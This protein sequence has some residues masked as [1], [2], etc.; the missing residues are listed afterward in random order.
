MDKKRNL[1]LVVGLLLLTISFISASRFPTVGGDNSTWGSVLNDYLITLSGENATFLNKTF[2]N[3]SNIYISSVNSTHIKDGTISDEDISDSTN[4]T[5]GQK[6]VFE[7]GESIGNFIDGWIFITG[8]LNMSNNNITDVDYIEGY[9]PLLPITPEYPLTKYLNGNRQWTSIIVGS[10]ASTNVYFTN[11]TSDVSGY[12]KLS[13]LN[14]NTEVV[15]EGT[16]PAGEYLARTYLYD[17]QIGT[18]VIDSGLWLANYN[19][20]VSSKVQETYMKFEAFMRNSNGTET[21]LFSYY[22]PEIDNTDYATL[23]SEIIEPQFNINSTERF[24]VRIYVNTSAPTAVTISSKVGGSNP[25]YFQL[26]IK[27]RHTNLRDLNGD[28][29]YLHYSSIG[30]ITISGNISAGKFF[31]EG[32]VGVN[33]SGTSCTI[34]EITNGIITGA[35]CS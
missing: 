12:K 31:S 17:S 22:S 3:E 13:Y 2:V 9:E 21:T 1:I 27:Q 25:S 29:N 14:D 28:S 24:G 32:R 18:D 11:Q 7:F 15:F 20:K 6:I 26:P 30:N 23:R 10:S 34:T 5:L 19:V 4:L 35:T 8:N 16:I 33:A